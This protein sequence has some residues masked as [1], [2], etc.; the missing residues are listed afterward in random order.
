MIF[1]KLFILCISSLAYIM[2]AAAQE[3]YSKVS[4]PLTT[5]AVK[6]FAID[7]L[8][9][10]H[11]I[12]ER[13]SIVAVLNSTEL[14]RLRQS[15]H[16]FN[17]LID[18]VVSYTTELNRNAV[19]VEER[20]P[21]QGNGCQRVG[22]LISTPA[23]F[24][25]G[26][27][28]RLGASAANP[29][30]FTYA[31]MIAKMQALAVAY[32]TMVSVYSI[33]NSA[34][35]TAIYGVKISDNVSSDENEPEVLYTGLQHAREAIGGTSLIFFAQ[36]LAENYASNTSVS[37]LVNNREIFIIPCMNP[38]G[39]AYNYSGTSAS[40]PVT[41]GGLWRKNR[42]N[43][44][45]GASNIGVDINRN[46]SIDW[47]NCSGAS[48]SCGS[49]VK[50]DETYY[51][52]SAFSE[53]E[54]QALRDF[55][56]SR[57][58]VNAIDQHCYGPYFSL[59]YGRPSLHPVL[60]HEDSAYYTHIPALMGLYNGHRA[61]NSP[62]T[63]AYEVAGGIKDWLLLGDI[64]TG[65]GPKGKI[66]GMTGE[67]GGGDFW[68]PVTQIIQLCK[69]N[70]FQNLQMALAAG[71]YYDVQ[72]KNDISINDLSGKFSFQLRRIGLGNNPVTVTLVPIQN[73]SSVG[74]PVTTTLANYNDTYIDSIA[75]NL[76]TTFVCGQKISF[77]WKVESGGLT[78]Y[79]TISKY[80]NPL[81]LF[82]DDMEGSF[83]SKWTGTI[84]PAGPTGW[85][86]TTNQSH[87]GTKS[88]TESPTGNYTTSSTRTATC[89]TVF[90]LSDATHAYISFW[91]KH[92]AENFRDKLQVQVSTGGAWSPLC[93]TTT[94]ME[95]NSTSG[96][97]LNG[98]PALT[99]IRD[100]WTRE[101]FDL[102]GYI[103]SATVSLR[104]RFTSDNDAGSF[105]FEKD[106]GFYI[107]DISVVKTTNVSVIGVK[108]GNFTGKLLSNQTVQLDWEAYTDLQHDYF[109]VEKA[110]VK[111]SQFVSIAKINTMPPYRAFDLNPEEG[112][113]YYRIKQVDK[114]GSTTYSNIVKIAVN[115][116]RSS[117]VMYPNPVKDQLNIR[118]NSN[119]REKYTVQLSDIRGRLIQEQ[120]IVATQ[121]NTAMKI[122]VD[123][124]NPQLYIIKIINGNNEVICTEKFIK[125]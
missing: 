106:D 82:S 80:V 6:Q 89:N 25:T 63:V 98:Q 30:Y 44:G 52:P 79:D 94:V 67:A 62:E 19:P 47:G 57:H 17:I 72:D 12:T 13:N 66:F 3:K 69:E 71:D 40:Y 1:K 65:S 21:F 88:M 60:S 50:T 118:F 9:L 119:L 38:D 28:L 8:E 115:P 15:G 105:A 41:G 22:N 76:P 70:C 109:E 36:Y 110:S 113:N 121:G 46:Y 123:K 16:A 29:G 86:F 45:G 83:A 64:G 85:D 53:P 100:S 42:R 49:N 122:D 7:K 18:D 73:I 117:L 75:Y 74:A 26:G 55:V 92:R 58:F 114:N 87:G 61:G 33:G 48:S 4:I 34:A 93:G 27:S 84:S 97:L 43:T 54:T 32:P 59:P 68:A 11:Y 35:G 10:D 102:S 90:D 39:Y 120:N 108:Y 112:M 125:E 14:N 24:G 23:S 103:G 31:E 56:Y 111:N 20:S 81:V 37:G 96:G 51:G 95:N 124:L 104:F 78:L 107:D 2:P 77:A 116:D 5:P 91:V 101:L 99:G